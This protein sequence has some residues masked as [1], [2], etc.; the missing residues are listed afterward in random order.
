MPKPPLKTC[1]S[2]APSTGIFGPEWPK[3]RGAIMR[4]ALPSEPP[5]VARLEAVQRASAGADHALVT[6]LD[7]ALRPVKQRT[8]PWP[9]DGKVRVLRTP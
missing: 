2:G 9:P 7:E 4:I 8:L 6:E 3:W 1:P 5:F